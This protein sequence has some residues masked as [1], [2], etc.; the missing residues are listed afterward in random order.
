MEKSLFETSV[1]PVGRSLLIRIHKWAKFFYACT[2]ATFLFDGWNAWLVAKAF[3][4]FP[5]SYPAAL[6]FQTAASI[7]FLVIYGILLVIQAYYFLRFA[8][9]STLALDYE[10]GESFNDAFTFLLRHI[11]TATILFALNSIWA[12]LI[13]FVQ[14]QLHS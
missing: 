12:F 4:Q 11:I 13:A 2:I 5:D 6:R 8:R 9:K 3:R 14:T 7:V 1:S 10:N